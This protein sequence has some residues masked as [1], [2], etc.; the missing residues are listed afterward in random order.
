MTQEKSASQKIS[1]AGGFVAGALAACGAVT[2][3]NPIELVKTRMQLQGELSKANEKIY[4]NPLQALGK[5]YSNEGIRGLQKGL[6]AAYVYQVCLNGCRLGLYE[7]SRNLLNQLF[8]PNVEDYHK[9]Q[10]IPVNVAAGALSGIAGAILGSPLFLIKTRMQSYSPIAIGDQTHYKSVADGLK[11]IYR[12]NGFLGLFKGVDAAIIRTGM[13]SSVQL[14]IYN[15]TKSFI[16]N[17]NL[18]SDPSSPQLHLISSTMSGIGVGIV[19]NPG[20]V[21]LTRVYNQKGNNHYT[22]PVDCFIKIIKYEGV[23]ALYKGFFAQLLRVAP[24]TILTLTFM[25]QTMKFCQN[26]EQKVLGY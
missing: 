23:G 4:K 2:F 20:D 11:Q 10:S 16:I 12:Q 8:F 17:N 3:T 1:T 14:P 25:E 6:V 13:G 22:G 26:I 15:A 19:M 5:I 7:P 9:V 24:H 18:I 21:I